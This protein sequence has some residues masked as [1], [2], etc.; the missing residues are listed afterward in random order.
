MRLRNLKEYK[1]K[2]AIYTKDDELNDVFSG[3]EEIG[4]IQAD[5]QPSSGQLKT[6]QYGKEIVKYHTVFCYPS[7][8]IKE[9]LFVEYEGQHHE[10]QAIQKWRHWTF[11]IKVVE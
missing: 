7:E 11:D 10:I 8:L 9:G 3:Y 1:L 6:Q 4:T 5:I 2:K